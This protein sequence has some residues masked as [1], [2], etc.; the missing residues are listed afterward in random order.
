MHISL[1]ITIFVI[2]ERDIES[3]IT[4]SGN[5]SRTKINRMKEL[6]NLFCSMNSGMY[7]ASNYISEDLDCICDDTMREYA[8]NTLAQI[9]KAQT[10]AKQ[11]AE[12]IARTEFYLDAMTDIAMSLG[13]RNIEFE[14]SK[15]RSITIRQ[16]VQE[17]VDKYHNTE[18]G[19]MAYNI[20]VEKF[21]IQKVNEYLQHNSQTKYTT[22]H[23]FGTEA[24]RIYENCVD[25]GQKWDVKTLE[26]K[27]SVTTQSFNSQKELNAYILGVEDATGYLESSKMMTDEEWEIYCEEYFSD[28]DNE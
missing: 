9:N 24:C 8:E 15:K 22:T 18:R 2:D 7:A 19:T 25:N 6:E 23:V 28:E 10:D 16:W 1:I 3:I 14:D 4:N 17:F 26:G 11:I 5:P 21:T 13:R 12:T 20:L 27:G